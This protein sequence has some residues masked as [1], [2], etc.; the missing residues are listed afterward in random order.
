MGVLP[1]QASFF[2]ELFISFGH[3]YIGLSFLLQIFLFSL[4]FL[5]WLMVFF[6]S[7]WKFF[8][9]YT[10]QFRRRK[11]QPTLVFL[12]GESHGQ[13]SLVGHSP[14]GHRKSDMSEVTEHALSNLPNISFMAFGVS[15]IIKKIFHSLRLCQNLCS[16]L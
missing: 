12:P 16:F 10:V 1:T 11:R 3:F 7:L 2:C 13:R 6:F 14:W 8:K 4:W 5:I 9:L 15:V